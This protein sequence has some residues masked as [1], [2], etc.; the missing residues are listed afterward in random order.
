MGRSSLVGATGSPPP[1][2]GFLGRFSASP[3]AGVA[4]HP[5]RV[6]QKLRSPQSYAIKFKKNGRK[7]ENKYTEGKRRTSQRRRSKRVEKRGIR[8][9]GKCSKKKETEGRRSKRK[10]RGQKR[11]IN[12]GVPTRARGGSANRSLVTD[13]RASKPSCGYAPSY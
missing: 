8:D 9:P 2:Q 3:A 11:R 7:M 10:F 12:L 4:S 13:P 1:I 6:S 5:P